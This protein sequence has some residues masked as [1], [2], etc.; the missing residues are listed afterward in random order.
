MIFLYIW[1]NLGLFINGA[2]VTIR[3]SLIAIAFGLIIGI[4]GALFRTSGNRLLNLN[5]LAIAYVEAICNTPFL[6]Q[7]FFIAGIYLTVSAQAIDQPAPL[8]T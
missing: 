4:M 6:I 5:L 7:L 8:E 3:L 2:F 1:D